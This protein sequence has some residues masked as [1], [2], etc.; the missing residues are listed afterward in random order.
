M[1]KEMPRVTAQLINKAE[2]AIQRHRMV[3]KG[4]TVI[5]AVSGGPDSVCLLDVLVSL[6]QVLE[7][8]L[9]ISHFNHLLRPGEDEE[10]TRFVKWLS[11]KYGIPCHMEEWTEGVGHGMG[12]LED[13]ARKARYEFFERTCK[14]RGG[15]TIAVGHNMND[16]AETVL[17]RL[18]RGAGPQ[19]LAG[20]DPV[21]DDHIIRPLLEIK[22]EEILMYLKAKDLPYMIDSSNRSPLYLRN[23]LRLELMPALEQI[24]PQLVSSLARLAGIVREDEKYLSGEAA[25][26]F[27]KMRK[28]IP[29]GGSIFDVGDLGP[30]HPSVR[31]RLIRHA[32]KFLK[33]DLLRI[34]TVHIEA[35]ERLIAGIKPNA[36]LRLPEGIT[37]RREYACLIVERC[38]GKPSTLPDL[39]IN[40]PGRYLIENPPKE[41]IVE[42]TKGPLPQGWNSSLWVAHLDAEL[43]Q[44]PL[45]LRSFRPGDR[46]FP[47]GMD[48]SKKLKEF[49]IDCKVPRSQRAL[50]PI[51]ACGNRIAWVC[52]MR[53][54]NRFRLT[55]RTR[56]ILKISF[57]EPFHRKPSH[58]C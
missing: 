35:I 45:N 9:V 16:Q 38:P 19:G 20:I 52:G 12:S 30:L 4:D 3:K 26:F 56:N 10:E 40:G 18:L 13:Q 49:F 17:M 5:V 55:N 46:F 2:R 11:E 14:K 23:R 39:I 57:T 21:R 43:V 54:D 1:E 36:V 15:A 8:K 31:G 28:D 29:G 50:V 32:I 47:L 41:I 58:A 25:V 34:G 48:R 42:E 51:L 44:F 27:K 22:R 24:Q 6:S 33:G 7:I 53:I 37:V